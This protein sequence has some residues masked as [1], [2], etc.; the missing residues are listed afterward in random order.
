MSSLIISPTLRDMGVSRFG[1]PTWHCIEVAAQQ[2]HYN[3][4]SQKS[5]EELLR[6]IQK[7]PK[8]GQKN[9]R[10]NFSL[11][12][13]AIAELYIR[14][15][16]EILRVVRSKGLQ[17]VDAE[18]ITMEVWIVALERIRGFEWRG[19]PIKKWLF[20][21]ADKRC[22]VHF[23]HC[24]KENRTKSAIQEQIL[25]DI[26]LKRNNYGHGV[27]KYHKRAKSE[28]L[29]LME[30]VQRLEPIE[31]DIIELIYFDNKNSREIGELL[32]LRPVTVRQKHARAKRKIEENFT[33]EYNVQNTQMTDSDS[34]TTP[35]SGFWQ[36]R[37]GI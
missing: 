35:P 32:G 17:E 37:I 20:S 27:D 1:Y 34:G 19:I 36:Q 28:I 33:K 12:D 11:Q 10:G 18:D 13:Q 15:T 26:A 14:Y 24:K 2:G 29:Q 3:D 9:Y 7:Q 22:L 21:I 25:E 23:G 5:D 31:Q 6:L 16:E 30:V 4:F 8:G